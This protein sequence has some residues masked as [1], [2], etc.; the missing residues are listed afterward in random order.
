M[1]FLPL[2]AT[3]NSRVNRPHLDAARHWRP[4]P[5]CSLSHS[6]RHYS[7]RFQSQLR[8]TSDRSLDRASHCIQRTPLLRTTVRC[9]TT[10]RRW[11]LPVVERGPPVTT[12]VHFESSREHPM[13]VSS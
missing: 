1:D 3:M 10:L 8:A 2:T 6:S 13:A 7:S 5:C 4:T 12:S 11:M 9:Q